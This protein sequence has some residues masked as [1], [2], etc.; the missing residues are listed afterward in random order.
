MRR[1]TFF[2]DHD[3]PDDLTYSLVALDHKVILLRDVL[4]ITADD[5]SV[6]KYAAE[7]GYVLITCNRDDFLAAAKETD[8]GGIILL[9]RRTTRVSERVALINLL[10]RAGESGIAGNINFA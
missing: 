5:V 4:P 1:M 2:L 3:A 9:I 6:L 8:H 7:R 10:D